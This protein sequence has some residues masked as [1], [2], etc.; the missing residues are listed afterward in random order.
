[1]RMNP[2]TLVVTTWE[3]KFSLRGIVSG[4][5]IGSLE[6]Q[7]ASLGMKPT[8]QKVETEDGERLRDNS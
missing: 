4:W 2:G 3:Q 6:A 8:Q 5:E 7:R 1:M